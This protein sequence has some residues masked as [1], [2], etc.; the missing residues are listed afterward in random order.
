MLNDFRPN[1]DVV[2]VEHTC[3]LDIPDN[4][5]S[6]KTI[7]NLTTKTLH[8]WSGSK[9]DNFLQL[10]QM[11]FTRL[12]NYNAV[13]DGDIDFTSIKKIYI[14]KFQYKKKVV[15]LLVQKLF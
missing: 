12:R 13:D 6:A 7:I 1:L 11:L 5:I 2:R 10:F 8:S 15:D 4:D 3:A 14:Q 9:D